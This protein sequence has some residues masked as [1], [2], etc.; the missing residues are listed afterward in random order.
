MICEECIK[1]LGPIASMPPPVQGSMPIRKYF[2]IFQFFLTC[3]GIDSNDN[4]ARN[5]LINDIF[6]RG[7]SVENREIVRRDLN[8]APP[9]R[10][11]IKDITSY[12]ATIE[13]FKCTIFGEAK[14]TKP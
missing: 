8:G 2:E 3:L 13:D 14:D 1:K 10:L 12:L 5:I 6:I 11:E 7:L 4:P 9:G